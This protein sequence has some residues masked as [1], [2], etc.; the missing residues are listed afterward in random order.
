MVLLADAKEID[1][2][3]VEIIQH[4]HLGRLLVEEHLGAAGECLYIGG[5]LRQYPKNALG[6]RP[7]PTYV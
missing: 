6:E 4:F 3:A 1:D 2:L 5:V 7:F